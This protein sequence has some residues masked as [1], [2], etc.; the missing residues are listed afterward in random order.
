MILL[1]FLLSLYCWTVIVFVTVLLGG[2]AGIVSFVSP[3]VAHNSAKL[4]GKLILKL[5]LIKVNVYGEKNIIALTSH[6]TASKVEK[7]S[8]GRSGFY[9]ITANHQS[10]FD[11]FIL[12]AYLPMQFK[13]IAKKS[14]FNIPILGL[15]MKRLGYIPI[16]RENLRSALKTVKETTE[17]LKNNIS[18]L[19]FP[20]GTRSVN[21][22][23]SS[24]KKGGLNMF[25]RLKGAKVLPIAIKGSIEILK[26][27]SFA[28]H[29]GKTVELHILNIIDPNNIKEINGIAP[30]QNNHNDKTKSADK[31][32]ENIKYDIIIK[33]IEDETKNALI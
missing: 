9:I 16:D 15:S 20:E 25:L 33:K 5:C 8:G 10:Y 22:K 19:L 26:K 23:L 1:N 14:L 28:I 6:S 30:N 32:I 21:G 13:F 27:N 7:N 18:I 2:F 24:F 29:P 12:L 3:K 4:W 11:I 17:V 31:N